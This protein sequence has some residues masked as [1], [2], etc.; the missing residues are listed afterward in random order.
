LRKAFS[1]IDYIVFFRGDKIHF[2][3]RIWCDNQANSATV[4]DAFG[5][6]PADCPVFVKI[7]IEGGEYRILDDLLRYGRNI[8]AIAIE[9]HDVDI[10]S[11]RFNS[12]VDKI[13]RDFYIVHLHANNMGGMAPF[14]FPIAPE[15]TFLNKRF[16]SAPPPPSGSKYPSP[17]LDQ[18]NNPRLPE[19]T[20]EF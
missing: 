18:P 3:Q 7:D 11:D 9:F 6:L 15:L 17:G 19:F 2:Q 20:F 1:W 10:L 5:R 4:Q 12:L 13:K 16:F 8:V 14:G